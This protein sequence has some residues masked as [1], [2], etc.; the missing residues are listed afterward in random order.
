MANKPLKV[1]IDTKS[2][3]RLRQYLSQDRTKYIF[4]IIWQKAVLVPVFS[5]LKICRDPKD[6]FILNLA[7][8]AQANCIISGDKDLLTLHP[9][10]TIKILSLSA[11]ISN[12]L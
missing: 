6:D 3:P 9:F 11:F 8:D 5:D 1:V 12:S 4:D 10:N 2:K 7:S